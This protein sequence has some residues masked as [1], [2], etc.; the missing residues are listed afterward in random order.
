M[1][2][3]DYGSDGVLRELV[4]EEGRLSDGSRYAVS[5]NGYGAF[6]LNA[7]R[8]VFIDV[9]VSI[10]ISLIDRLKGLFGRG[11]DPA[12]VFSAREREI[13][14]WQRENSRYSIACYRTCAGFRLVIRN[15]LAGR[16][17]VRCGG[18]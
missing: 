10:R 18:S 6:V 11:I 16:R 1:D 17:T 12:A 13:R 9:D 4:I 14:D 8:V 2:R 5:R 3:Y 15:L 7:E